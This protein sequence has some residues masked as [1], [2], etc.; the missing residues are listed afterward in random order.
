MLVDFIDIAKGM[1]ISFSAHAIKRMEERSI[2]FEEI[3][4]KVLA[5]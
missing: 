2:G 5:K 3:T 1:E 4:K